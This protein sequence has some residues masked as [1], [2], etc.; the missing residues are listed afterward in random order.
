MRMWGNWNDATAGGV[1]N[2]LATLEKSLEDPQKV[3]H[4][5][6]TGPKRNENISLFK[7]LYTSIYNAI[8]YK[9]QKVETT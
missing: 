6:A 7:N 3:K 9:S 4:R 5:V 8:I 1:K 2:G